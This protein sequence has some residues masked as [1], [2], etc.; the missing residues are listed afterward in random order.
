MPKPRIDAREAVEDIKEGLDDASLMRK[1]NISAKGLQ[2]LLRKL[3]ASGALKQ[4]EIDVR[5]SERES[6]VIIDYSTISLDESGAGTV[7]QP[8]PNPDTTCVLAISQDPGLLQCVKSLHRT[9]GMQVSTYE[10]GL[11]DGEFF[12]LLAPQVVLTDMDE[13]DSHHFAVIRLVRE[14]DEYV[15]IVLVV[16]SRMRERALDAIEAGAYDFIEKP[17]TDRLLRSALKRG[18]DYNQ[19]S[20]SRRDQSLSLEETV[21]GVPQGIAET[22]D[23]LKGILNSST[24]VSVILTDVDQN[25]RFWNKGAENIFGYTAE[26]MT[27][28]K[29]T[30]LYPP[31]MLTKGSV[32]ELRSLVERKSSTVQA[33]MRQVAKDGRVLTIAL[34]VSPLLNVSGE[35]EGIVG[36]G[37]DVTEEVRQNKEI[38][39]LLHQVKQTQDVAVFAL[40][41]LTEARSG[42]SGD[43]L[44]RMQEYCRVLGTALAKRE[45]YAEHLTQKYLDD[46]IKSAV[47]HDIGKVALPDDILLHQG[48]YTS[49]ERDKMKQHTLVGGKALQDAVKKLGSE[50]FLTVAM[51]LAFYHHERWDG[52]G[53]PI[54][55]QEEEIPVSARMLAIGD[56]YDALTS[57]RP[58]RKAMSHEEASSIIAE[59]AGKEFDPTLVE[60]YRELQGEFKMIRSVFS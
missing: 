18:L 16:D 2:S 41:K 40:A 31:D 24:M 35:L 44:T 59:G 37:L 56:V 34:A 19:L 7:P 25:I 45:K 26:E 28:A 33:K 39:K 1:H 4:S 49:Q 53:Y 11:P 51:E 27:G 20:R 30:R 38:V 42:E 43:H 36:I 22:D 58:Y 21:V 55:L 54:G 5:V 46:L 52:T 10:E 9:D 47:L 32:E 50:S 12:E 8:P 48:I 17:I 57:D 29:I 23:F 60:E 13:S 6:S 3:V 15:P 14:F